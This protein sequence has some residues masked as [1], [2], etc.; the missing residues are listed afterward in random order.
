[1]HRTKTPAHG[2]FK[3]T[4]TE[5]KKLFDALI[6]G[7]I[8]D[9]DFLRLEA[10]LSVDAN[11]RQEF[12]KRLQLDL[13]LEREA[14]SQDQAHPSGIQLRISKQIKRPIVSSG[15]LWR[16]WSWLRHLLES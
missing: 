15:W 16:A 10:E 9:A 8:S 3:M 11:V 12:Y 1:M 6:D 4:P 13:L 2:E 14:K 7:D 5:R